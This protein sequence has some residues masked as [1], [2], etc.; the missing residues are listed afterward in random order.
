M[1]AV[2]EASNLNLSVTNLGPIAR[3]DIDLRPMT[4]FVGPSNTGKSYLAILIY[5]LH[6]YF[7]GGYSSP[8][9][10]GASR[11]LRHWRNRLPNQDALTDEDLRRLVRWIDESFPLPEEASPADERASELPDFVASRIRPV[12]RDLGDSGNEV[13]NEVRRSFGIPDTKRLVRHRSRGGLQVGLRYPILHHPSESF[14]YRLAISGGKPRFTSSIPDGAP[15]SIESFGH[16]SD[17]ALYPAVLMRVRHDLESLDDTARGRAVAYLI[18]RITDIVFPSTI[19]PLSRV[20]HYLPADRTGIMHAHLIAVASV[21]ERAPLTALRPGR[22]MPEL[23]GVLADFLIRLVTLQSFPKEEPDA[24]ENPSGLLAMRLEDHLLGGQILTIDSIT[25]YPEFYYRPAGWD[26]ALPLMNT[27]S[28]VSELAPVVLYLRHVVWPGE[29]LIIE[30]PESHLHPA[31]QV[32]FIRHLAAAVRAGIRIMITTHSEWVL[33]E[34]A[35]LV[36][37]SDAPESKREG[38]GGSAY[39]LDRAQVGVWLFEPKKRPRGAVV[40]EIPFDEDF[41]GF[42]SGFDEVAIGTYNNYAEIS[43]RIEEA[44]A[45][46]GA[47]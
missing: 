2:P 42:R 12:L 21:L 17:R 44:R 25:G 39:A 32:E 24:D 36:R 31:M 11:A 7:G 16:A 5:A 8:I 45:E 4:V 43:N 41:G 46:Y 18:R 28:M 6:R 33:D 26:S 30:E 22:Y 47:R 14:E 38:I 29:V 35:N 1:P 9:R 3:A 13:T 20:A 34:L 37:L 15:L 27:S 10:L 23:S 40:K 19:G